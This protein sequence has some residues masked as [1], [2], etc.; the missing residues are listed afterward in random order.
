MIPQSNNIPLQSQS[1]HIAIFNIQL[2]WQNVPLFKIIIDPHCSEIGNG[3]FLAEPFCGRWIKSTKCV[4]VW[5]G[6][7]K[8][9][10]TLTAKI[11]L[12]WK[13]W[14]SFCGYKIHMINE[15][16]S[17]CLL[18]DKYSIAFNA[19]LAQIPSYKT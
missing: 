19:F 16:F 15:N 9:K 1:I 4:C 17:I 13:F 8:I 2:S 18:S 10:N 5:G 6:G 11:N 12:F 7:V 14:Y 3:C